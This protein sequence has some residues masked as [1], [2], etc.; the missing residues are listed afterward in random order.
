MNTWASAQREILTYLTTTVQ[1]V[2][3]VG[4]YAADTSSV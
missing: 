4:S 2:D 1:A 3:S